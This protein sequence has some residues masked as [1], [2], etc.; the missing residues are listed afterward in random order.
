MACGVPVVGTKVGGLLDTIEDGV[1]GLLVPPCRPD[2]IAAAIRAVLDDPVRRRALGRAGA[3]RADR[4][5]RW[6]AV[7]RDVLAV[8]DGVLSTRVARTAVTA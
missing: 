2:Q 4:L 7:A 5:Y 8:Y 6:P 3:R 1:N